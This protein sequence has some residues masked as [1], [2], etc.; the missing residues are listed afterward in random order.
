MP[1]L[2]KSLITLFV[3][4]HNC[5]FAVY[6][7]GS[8]EWHCTEK[9][10]I[11]MQCQYVQNMKKKLVMWGHMKHSSA[12]R[13]VCISLSQLMRPGVHLSPLRSASWSKKQQDIWRQTVYAKW[14]LFGKAEITF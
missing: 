7:N 9:V 6:H 1:A 4:I 12:L 3:E 2:G 10:V 13:A 5:F 14:L 11:Q 8:H